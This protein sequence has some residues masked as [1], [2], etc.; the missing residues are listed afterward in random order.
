MK[1]ATTGST[2]TKKQIV[3]RFAKMIAKAEKEW[4]TEEVARLLVERN[5]L[6]AR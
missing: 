4:D 1:N 3:S 5:R 6:L 2:E